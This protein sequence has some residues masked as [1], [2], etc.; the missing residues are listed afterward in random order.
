M[1]S[2]ALQPRARMPAAARGPHPVGAPQGW[3]TPGPKCA[4]TWLRRAKSPRASVAASRTWT[5]PGRR[6]S[7]C[8]RC[9]HAGGL[10]AKAWVWIRTRC[11]HRVTL[12]P[13]ASDLNAGGRG[14]RP[15]AGQPLPRR[16]RSGPH[17]SARARRAAPGLC[18]V[19]VGV[20]GGGGLVCAP[21]VRVK[22][23]RRLSCGCFPQA[24]LSELWRWRRRGGG[25]GDEDMR[26]PHEVRCCGRGPGGGGG[27]PRW[28]RRCSCL[29]LMDG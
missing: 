20:C 21:R 24:L 18:C 5:G 14:R 28:L 2:L 25:M 12:T 27:Q 8:S 13:N 23:A 19:C 6:S 3:T 22:L 11:C 7:C 26:R 16:R 15:A 1:P 4:S 29:G 10:H 9:C 17:P